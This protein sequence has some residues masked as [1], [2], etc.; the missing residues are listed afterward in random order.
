MS[1]AP[2]A[3][4]DLGNAVWAGY[5]AFE[6][7]DCFG[8][9][10]TPNPA[11]HPPGPNGWKWVVIVHGGGMRQSGPEYAAPGTSDVARY[12]VNNFGVAVL[13]ITYPQGGFEQPEIEHPDCVLWP[14]HLKP[15][16]WAVQ[17]AKLHAND[18][19]FVGVGGKL[20]TDPADISMSGLSAGAYLCAAVQLQDD[21]TFE[22]WPDG[23]SDDP[24]FGYEHNHFVGSV[25][26]NGGQAI[27]SKLSKG[28]PGDFTWDTYG[29]FGWWGSYFIS[30][31][32]IAAGGSIDDAA[33][34]P[35]K[36]GAEPAGMLTPDNPR[37]LDVAWYFI[38]QH[39]T[40]N[41]ALIKNLADAGNPDS[42]LHPDHYTLG[43]IDTDLTS[44][45]DESH[46]FRAAYEVDQAGSDRYRLKAGDATTNPN[47]VTAAVLNPDGSASRF[48][49]WRAAPTLVEV[50]TAITYVGTTVTITFF[51]NHQYVAGGTPSN[52]T[53]TGIVSSGTLASLLNG[54]TFAVTGV[55]AGDKITITAAST[56][57]GSYT[58]G[59]KSY[60]LG[61]GS[62]E[63]DYYT[64]LVDAVYGA[65]WSLL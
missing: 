54:N 56:P 30:C 16:A 17:F 39:D 35:M 2:Y 43:E 57:S 27:F 9:L 36:L 28:V 47:D 60:V 12:L 21:G 42:F 8:V 40:L 13:S 50:V 24:L 11:E 65:G 33:L 41:H 49:G 37:T 58:S 64:F 14:D 29:E 31:K 45:H 44:L 59:G 25:R 62:P 55:P 61:T 34:M 23:R 4:L 22:Y 1:V 38:A 19:W 5:Y 48:G 6:L 10:Y 32:W 51:K 18:E 7:P 15:P 26:F 20:S 46:A 52:V 3:S 53:L 63:E